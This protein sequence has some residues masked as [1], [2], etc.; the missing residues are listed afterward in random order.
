MSFTRLSRIDRLKEP[1]QRPFGDPVLFFPKQPKGLISFFSALIWSTGWIIFSLSSK[2]QT[3]S[4]TI[5][6]CCCCCCCCCCCRSYSS[7]DDHQLFLH[8]LF[9]FLSS[10]HHNAFFARS[11]LSLSE[12]LRARF[13][14]FLL[15]RRQRPIIM[16]KK[17]AKLYGEWVKLQTKKTSDLRE[18]VSWLEDF[19]PTRQ[20]D[21]IFFFFFSALCILNLMCESKG[22]TEKMEKKKRKI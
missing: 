16:R 1:R 7:S 20:L 21:F 13:F 8:L 15:M 19:S 2:H 11:S 17:R 9:L 3:H 5:I 10:N 22:A 14:V 4:L 12:I 6:T 18:S